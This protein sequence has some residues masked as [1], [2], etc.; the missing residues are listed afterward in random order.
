[1]EGGNQARPQSVAGH[2]Q[3]VVDARLARSELQIHPGAAVQVEDVAPAVDQC[4]RRSDLL[5]ERLLGELAQRHLGGELRRGGARRQQRIG[6]P[7]RRQEM[8][9]Q[10]ARQAVEV[11]LPLIDLGLAVQRGEQVAELAH[12]L[13]S[14]QKQ[15]SARLQCVVKQRDERL[16]QFR[17]HVNEQVAAAD[18]VNPGKR[19][20]LDHVLLG[21]DQQVAD[22]LVNPIGAAVGLG[23]EKPRQPLRRHVHRDARRIESRPRRGD[24]PAVDVGG[25]DLHRIVAFQGFHAFHQQDG[26]RVGFLAGGASRRPDPDG[27][28]GGLFFQQL[29]N[30]LPLEIL[31]SLPV[32][33]KPRHADQQVPEQRL[34][35]RRSA[36]QEP[37]V[38]IDQLD[39][40]DRHPPVDA[41]MHGARLV[42]GEIMAG[43]G[44][45]QDENFAQLVHGLA[46]Q[47]GGGPLGLAESMG[48]VGNELGGH[49]RRRQLEIHQPGGDRA[50]RHAV[51]LGGLRALRHDHAALALDRPH[52]ERAVTA[53]TGKHD[54]DGPLVLVLRQRAE[55]EVDGQ[56]LAARLGRWQQLQR[57]IEKRHV[58]VRRDDVG[59]VRLHDHPVLHL[60]HLHPRAAADQVGQDALVVRCQMLH[61]HEGH[62]RLGLGRHPREKRLERRQS[63]CRRADANHRKSLRRLLRSCGRPDLFASPGLDF[64]LLNT[65]FL[66]SHDRVSTATNEQQIKTLSR[67]K[68]PKGLETRRVADLVPKNVTASLTW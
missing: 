33:E 63:S 12:P 62:P 48:G 26:D 24:R 53:V 36:L 34:R 22:V 67:S 23:R 17:P 32:P 1:M 3:D 46:G 59:A 57:A 6:R 47:R 25:E 61:Q 28:A 60:E 64:F 52:A 68:S 15:D 40:V 30:D 7:G 56:P 2:F 50:A 43:L 13:G 21:K 19:R 41:A 55:E 18:Q 35:L 8:A 5:Q 31:E 11:A 66:A 10:R 38:F 37:D 39:L 29:G 4:A 58:V 27:L 20:V 16:L 14:A 42:L 65:F 49:F 51:E 9:Q 54:A 44:A 45:Q